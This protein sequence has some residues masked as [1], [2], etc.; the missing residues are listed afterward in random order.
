MDSRETFAFKREI[1]VRGE[2]EVFVAG[3][4]PA[5]VAAALAARRQGRKVFLAEAR[6]CLGGMGTAGMVPIFMQ[7]ADG[8]HFVAGGIGEEIYEK[9]FAVG[10]AGPDDKFDNPHRVVNVRAEFLKR[11]YDQLL[12]EAGV[13]FAFMTQ[14][15]G[16]ER[17]GDRITHAVLCAKSGIFAVKAEMFVDCTGD[18]DMAAMAGAPFEKGDA[19]GTLMPGTLC[20]LWADVDWDAVRRSDS[21][22]DSSRLAEAF[23]DNVFTLK[24]YHLPG[25]FRVGRHTGGGN[26]GHTFGVDGTDE[27]SLTAALVWGRKSLVEYERYYK[28]YLKGFE[29][30]E[31]VATGSLLGVRETRRIMGDYVLCVED[32]KRRATFDDEIGRYSYPVDVHPPKPGKRAFEEFTKEFGEELRY[33][34][35]ESYGIP[36]RSLLPKGVANCLVAGRCIS[37]DREMQGSVRV[38]PGCFITGQA[39]GTAAALG[40]E[41]SLDA[42]SVDVSELQGRLKAMGAY[43]PNC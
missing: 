27:R 19:Q 42:R 41:K 43:L 16:V 36:Y 17:D 14:L 4:G 5:G 23:E 18:G 34:D 37:C 28:R 12:I 13:D 6:T 9:L 21:R 31:L 2:V 40:V 38:M 20:S 15:I 1:P 11:L 7:F 3:G 35:G 39:A 29:N 33:S 30:M 8:V 22:P 32:F 25:M 26:I 10:G 24:D